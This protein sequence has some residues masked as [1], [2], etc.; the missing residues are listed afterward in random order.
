[1]PEH[2]SWPSRLRAARLAAGLTQ[3]EVARALGLNQSVTISRYETEGGPVP[4]ADRVE[5]LIAA[6]YDIA[7][8]FPGA[9]AVRK[10]KR[11]SAAT[12]A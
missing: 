4:T 7:I 10:R 3:I 9:A 1:M 5:D 12:G 11:K 2:P 8:L 6:G